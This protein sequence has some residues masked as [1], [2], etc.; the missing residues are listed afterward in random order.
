MKKN[1]III[2]EDRSILSISGAD[3]KDF[4][5]NILT[6]DI[7]KV[8]ENNSIF[9][10]IFT[11]QGKYMYEFFVIKNKDKYFLECTTEFAED[12]ISYLSKYKLRS[13]IQIHNESSLFAVAII[14]LDKFEEIK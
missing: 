3:A 9:S 12:L 5:Q 4:L 11:P 10:A 7:D 14:S 1:E 2:S 8:D 13:N 6:N